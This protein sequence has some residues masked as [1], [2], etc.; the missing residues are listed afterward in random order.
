M[1]GIF[2]EQQDGTYWVRQRSKEDDGK[3]Q[4]LRGR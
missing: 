2:E 4:G 1:F 3:K